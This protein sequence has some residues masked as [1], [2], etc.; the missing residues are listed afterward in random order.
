VLLCK[1]R[2]SNRKVITDLEVPVQ[3]GIQI[4]PLD[5]KSISEI[6]LVAQR[7]RLTL[8]EVLGEEVGSGVYSMDWL[9]QRVRFHLA[10]QQRAEVLL[11]VRDNGVICGHTIVRVE[12]DETGLEFGLF[13]TTYVDPVSRRLGVASLLLSQGEAWMTEQRMRR[14]ETYTSETN[15][16]L[17]R[18][19]EKH[20]YEIVDT[21]PEKKMVILAKLLG[22]TRA[23]S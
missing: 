23:Y 18:L 11:A 7:M 9:S 21:H 17:I 20:G 8:I 3:V 14:A 22:T 10:P 15:L 4:R 2:S 19:Y 6:D 5:P 13:S 1:R 12:K 16:K